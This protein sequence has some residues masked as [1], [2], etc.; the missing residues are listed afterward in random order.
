MK[1]R[2]TNYRKP[3][4]LGAA[5]FT[6]AQKAQFQALLARNMDTPEGMTVA[7]AFASDDDELFFRYLEMIDVIDT[8]TNEVVAD[9]FLYPFGDGA[10]VHHGTQK[11]IAE[12]VQHYLNAHESTEKPWLAAFDAAWREASPTLGL[13]DPRHFSISKRDYETAN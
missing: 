8:E 2:L 5:K 12:I 1:L 11:M 9:L 7:E 13:L 10:V 3:Y 6:D 4:E